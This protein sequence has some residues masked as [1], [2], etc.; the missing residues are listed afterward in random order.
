MANTTL[1]PIADAPVYEGAPDQNY[2]P[3]GDLYVRTRDGQNARSFLMF[4]LGTLPADADITRAVLRLNCYSVLNLIPGVS[5]VQARRTDDSWSE[6]GIT[7]KSSRY[8]ARG[9]VEDTTPPAVG[10]VEWT[11]TPFVQAKWVGNKIVSIC[12]TCAQEWYDGA[13]RN[14]SYRSKEY[15][16]NDP[17]LYIEYMIP[18]EPPDV[19]ITSLSHSTKARAGE[20]VTIDW[21]LKNEGGDGGVPQWT[22][23]RDLDTGGLVPP[24]EMSFSLDP[25]D[26]TGATIYPTMPN[27]NW[28]LRAETGYDSTLTDSRSFTITLEAPAPYVN[29][30]TISAPS[31]HV[32]D[33]AFTISGYVRDQF[34]AG[35]GGVTVYLYRNGSYIGSDGTSSSGYYAKSHIIPS[36]GI[37]EL[38]AKADTKWA[39]TDITIYPAEEPKVAIICYIYDENVGWMYPVKFLFDGMAYESIDPTDIFVKIMGDPGSHEIEAIIPG[40]DFLYWV[41]PPGE[42]GDIVFSDDGVN[43]T[44]INVSGLVGDIYC[45]VRAIPT[46]ANVTVKGRATGGYPTPTIRLYVY[47]NGVQVGYKD[48][49][50]IS[51]GS[52]YTYEKIVTGAGVHQVYGRMRLRNALGSFYKNTETVEFELG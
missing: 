28:R 43:P 26:V 9:T 48:F 5:D 42:Y 35:V 33:S 34:G 37:H 44:T 6:Y 13:T 20:E 1:Y 24:G 31:S 14:S 23:I 52:W 46:S 15:D 11:V 21:F 29:S 4:H 51:I 3:Y 39:Y 7:W 18:V 30:V 32:E 45:I 41:S 50:P 16:G 12:L 27:R 25:G 2:G 19:K 49:S 40:Y 10:W 8:M 36:P 17:E 47:D 38:A 22:R